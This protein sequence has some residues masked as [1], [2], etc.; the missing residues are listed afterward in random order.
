MAQLVIGHIF[1]QLLVCFLARLC[2][3]Y[4]L[5]E[6]NEV[7]DKYLFVHVVVVASCGLS[8]TS[9][10][11]KRRVIWAETRSCMRVQDNDSELN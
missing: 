1:E 7:H 4:H 5:R 9:R 11:R 3:T 2:G 6:S 10:F 8:Y